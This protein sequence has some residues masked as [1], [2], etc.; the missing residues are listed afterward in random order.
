MITT[1]TL[2]VAIDKTYEVDQLQKGEVM[3]VGKCTKTPGGKG[4]NVTRVIKLCGEEVVATG[5]VGG[6]SG[7]YV[8]ELLEELHRK[9]GHVS[10]YWIMTELLL[11]F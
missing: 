1:V 10:M 2:N 4:L 3:R 7:A 9:R 5:F 6:H 11:S 8:E